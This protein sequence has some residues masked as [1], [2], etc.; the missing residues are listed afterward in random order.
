MLLREFFEA[1]GNEVAI[2]FGRFNP[3]HKGHRAAW[4]VAAKSPVWYVG[5]HKATVGPKDPLPFDVKIDC[6]EA[7]WP[8]VKGHIVA[9]TSWLTLASKV[10]EEHKASVLYCCTDE[11]W[12]TKTVIQYNG[13]EGAHG[14]Y[15]FASIEQKPTPRLSSATDLRSAVMLGD[16]NAF[17]K[18]AGVN[19]DLEINGTPFFDL[20]AKYL[21]PYA[22]TKSGKSSKASAKLKEVN[23]AMSIR[24]GEGQRLSIEQLAHISDEALDNAYHYGRSSPGNTFGWQANL[25]SAEYAK[26]VIDN[27]ETELEIIADAIH[28]GWNETARAFVQNPGQFDDTEKLMAAGK[29][30]AKI[31]QREKLMNISYDKLPPDE[32]E[33]DL[34]VAR[35]LLAALKPVNEGISKKFI[36]RHQMDPDMYIPTKSVDNFDRRNSDIMIQMIKNI[37]THGKYPLQFKDGSELNLNSRVTQEIL[38]MLTDM[39]PK[40]KHAAVNHIAQSKENFINFV[41][42]KKKVDEDVELDEV[43]AF[44]GSFRPRIGK[45]K[46]F[47]HFGSEQAA[48]ERLDYLTAQD[49]RFKGI[50]TGYLYKLDLGINN[51]ATVKDYPE[52]QDPSTGNM[53]KIAAWANDLKKDPRVTGYQYQK[54]ERSLAWFA[55]NAKS[56]YWREWMRPEAF[57]GEFINLLEKMGID[58][59]VYKNAV[60]HKGQVSYISFRPENVKIVGRAKPVPLTPPEGVERK[61]KFTKPDLPFPK[62]KPK[63]GEQIF[64]I[65]DKGQVFYELSAKDIESVKA[66]IKDMREWGLDVPRG[67]K[68]VPAPIDPNPAPVA[69]PVKKKVKEGIIDERKMAD[70]YHSTDAEFLP[71]I[72]AAGQLTPGRNDYISLTRDKRY[73]YGAVTADEA[74]QFVIDQAKLAY[75]HKIE[76]YDWH[77]DPNDNDKEAYAR[78]TNYRRSESEE[79]VKGPLSLKYV[80]EIQLPKG[81]ANPK[82]V[83]NKYSDLGPN[84]KIKIINTIKKMGIKISFT[85]PGREMDE[86]LTEV[87][88]QPYRYMLTKKLPDARQYVFQTD[89]GTKFQVFFSLLDSGT[90]KIADVGF[91]DQTDKDNPTIG[92]TG[93]GDAFRVFST[94]GAIVKEYVNSVKPDF[95]SFNGKTQDPGRIKLYD[96]IAKNITRYLKDYEQSSHTMPGA[97]DEKG[98]MLQRI[99]K[100]VDE[101]S[102]VKLSSDP[103]NFGAWVR[104]GG[105]PEKTIVIPTSKIHVFE[106]DSKFDDPHHAKN[107]ANIVKAIKAGKKLPP[108]LVRRHGIDRFQVVDGHHR[109]MAYR[110]AGA[111]SIP[112]RVIDPKNVKEV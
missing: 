33:K 7:I 73:N 112:A 6:M 102:K 21:L 40:E 16:R 18:A 35:A 42:S 63:P 27:G 95:L 12:V 19:A 61:E 91:A 5:T 38:F 52:L 48:K 43:A 75:N 37:D 11:D 22:D 30:D 56:G 69:A 29:L 100:P 49:P 83:S 89:S 34:V 59:F 3:P 15:N 1:A 87:A 108:I 36:Q 25:K 4:E 81:W 104:D 85:T 84:D 80:K 106:P 98:Y 54:D 94:V 103:D 110:M 97:N 68:I 2:I 23:K 66:E 71:K 55:N 74:V 90:E 111:K 20:V 65:L 76:P 13:K 8:G 47:S 88:D 96:M 60:E 46:M 67:Y 77:M 17:T 31:A 28:D 26:R 14:Y 109:F 32:Q 107:L 105:T 72:L 79:R 78:D 86:S 64:Y 92:V 44:H 41:K 70:L 93:K 101:V 39:L 58:G 51:P 45:F 50:T 53:A 82:V 99:T 10:Y 57:I 24:E 9:E 62:E